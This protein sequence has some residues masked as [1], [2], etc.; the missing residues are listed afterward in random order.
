MALDVNE[1]HKITRQEAQDFI[2]N[3]AGNVGGS[4]IRGGF[5]NKNPL[6]ELLN[7][8]GCIGLRYY[9]GTNSAGD[10]VLVLFG[11]DEQEHDIDSIILEKSSPW[12]PNH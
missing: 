3:F 1:D 7:Q 2:D 4:E 8:N 5:F 6:I 9:Y 10:P 12:P 11:V